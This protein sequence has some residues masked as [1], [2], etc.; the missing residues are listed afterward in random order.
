MD[1]NKILGL[2]PP[3]KAQKKLKVESQGTDDIISEILAAH[4]YFANDYDNIADQFYT[5]NKL[6]TA[7]R[8]WKFLKSNVKYSIEPDTHQS[9]KSPAAILATGKYEHGG[10]DCKHYSLF[11]AG[12]LDAIN[13]KY[14]DIKF[15]WFYRFANYRITETQPQHVFVVLK[16]GGAEIWIDPVLPTFNNKKSFINKIDKKVALY[17]ISGAEIGRSKA[18]QAKRAVKK[19]ARKARPK[20]RILL[21]IAAAPARNAFLALVAV[22]FKQFAVHL[23]NQIQKDEAKLKN[24]WE[25]LGGN[26]SKLKNTI[27]KA[28]KKKGLGQVGFIGLAAGIAAAVPVIAKLAEFLGHA[29]EAIDQGK[30]II[31]SIRDKAQDAQDQQQAEP[32]YQQDQPVYQPA[33]PVYQEDQ[34]PVY[35]PAP[36]VVYQPAPPVYQEDQPVYMQPAPIPDS[37]GGGLQVRPAAQI[38]GFKMGNFKVRVSGIGATDVVEIKEVVKRPKLLVPALIGLGIFAY[39]KYKK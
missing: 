36:V 6:T 1:V 17:Q 32:V 24:K 2:L 25:K 35:Q 26:Y 15:E 20:K 18:K 39:S 12:I 3:Y 38:E 10:N 4:K 34:Q 16:I 21:K 37:S 30:G 29:K 28:A 31:T 13:R 14:P 33:P 5:G 27:L 8:I 19:A 9:V 11:T 7:K 22:N 23:Y